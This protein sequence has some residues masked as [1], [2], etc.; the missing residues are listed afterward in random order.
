MIGRDD[1]R[2][3]TAAGI[4]TE[5]QA[6]RLATLA[7]ER[8]GA[9]R[10]A[11][12]DDEPFELFQGFNEIFIVAGLAVLAAGWTTFTTGVAILEIERLRPALIT[13][14][15]IAAAVIWGLS[16]YFVRRR[17]MVAPA[18]VLTLFW[19]V[20]AVFGFVAAY[21]EPGIVF[22][23]DISEALLPL[24][25]GTLATF[26]FWGRF[27]VPIALAVVALGLFATALVALAMRAGEPASPG[28]LFLLSASGPLAWLTL[29]LGLAI[30]AAAMRFDMSDPHR[31]TR[32]AANGF[33]LHVVAAPAIVNTVALTLLLAEW[34][35]AGAV[36]IAFLALIALVAIVIDRRSFLLA[37][38]GYVVAL[39]A[40]MGTEGAAGITVLALGAAILILGAGWTSIRG[41]LMRR[42][43]LPRDRLPPVARA[44]SPGAPRP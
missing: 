10:L 25:L 43:P 11:G 44:L 22:E 31:V 5:A 6:A 3:A 32:R 39:S 19:A 30:F 28:D 21:F 16:E 29:I 36:L 26:V 38:V 4:V 27:H 2:A 17:R 35:G 33:W 12:R 40:R 1:L 20:N 41:A 34:P 14:A 37:G 9:R 13:Q 18:I 23:R 8:T 24:A 15:L 7:D 42:L